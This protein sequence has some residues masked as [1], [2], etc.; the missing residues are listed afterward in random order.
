ML[1]L[2]I[3]NPQSTS[4]LFSCKGLC[5]LQFPPQNVVVVNA[6]LCTVPGLLHGRLSL[7]LDG[8]LCIAQ[9]NELG[10]EVICV[11]SEQMI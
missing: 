9:V 10:T 4:T 2:I 11:S 6:V 1:T 8:A 5:H 7:W 3:R